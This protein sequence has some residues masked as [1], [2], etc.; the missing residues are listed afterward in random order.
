MFGDPPTSTL[1]PITQ[2]ALLMT[3]MRETESVVGPWRRETGLR[4]LWCRESNDTLSS[5]LLSLCVLSRDVRLPLSHR[6]CPKTSHFP[7]GQRPSFA[8][9]HDSC[10]FSLSRVFLTSKRLIWDTAVSPSPTPKK[11]FQWLGNYFPSLLDMS[12]SDRKLTVLG[13]RIVL[14]CW[15]FPI[16]DAVLFPFLVWTIVDWFSRVVN[17]TFFVSYFFWN[18]NYGLR[19]TF[20]KTKQYTCKRNQFI[21]TS[22]YY[23]PIYLVIS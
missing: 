1:L 7:F 16:F 19:M 13:Q 2:R 10:A 20:S 3:L 5:Y 6:E 17:I 18:F 14:T 15:I 11:C 4:V 9:K 21:Y 22:T 12:R 23:L 8:I